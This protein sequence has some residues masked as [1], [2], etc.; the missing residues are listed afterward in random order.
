[1]GILRL[2]CRSHSVRYD[3]RKFVLAEKLETGELVQAKPIDLNY[4][5][6]LPLRCEGRIQLYFYKKLTVVFVHEDKMAEIW[7]KSS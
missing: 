6:C 2:L 4:N 5:R 7:P 3:P 1:M